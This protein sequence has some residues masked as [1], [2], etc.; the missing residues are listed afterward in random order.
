MRNLSRLFQSN[1]N[2]RS[3]SKSR[4][5]DF[6][7]SM[8]RHEIKYSV[9]RIFLNIQ[10]RFVF[11]Y[12]QP[13]SV[14][15]RCFRLRPLLCH[16]A[17]LPRNP[18]RALGEAAAARRSV[19]IL[20]YLLFQMQIK[21]KQTSW[22]CIAP[23]EV[24]STFYVAETGGRHQRLKTFCFLLPHI[25]RPL[26]HPLDWLARRFF[27]VCCVIRIKAKTTC[28]LKILSFRCHETRKKKK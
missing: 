4:K 2:L 13:P 20:F 18:E 5:M 10:V 28:A 16:L 14:L 22:I 25:A 12:K 6:F 26:R 1:R 8:K 7:F 15:S 17:S 24:R 3:H 11:F 27:K 19:L 21:R 23:H 9:H